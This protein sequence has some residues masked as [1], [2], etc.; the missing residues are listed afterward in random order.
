MLRRQH[1]GQPG[2][3]S[4]GC[5]EYIQLSQLWMLHSLMLQLA[6]QWK[7]SGAQETIL[8]TLDALG[9]K[10]AREVLLDLSYVL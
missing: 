3:G 2:F 4:S 5:S 9:G 6:D 10:L 7:D 8:V 1:P